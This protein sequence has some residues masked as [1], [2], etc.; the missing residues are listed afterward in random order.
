MHRRIMSRSLRTASVR[1]GFEK[2][3]LVKAGLVRTGLVVALAVGPAGAALGQAEPSPMDGLLGGPPVQVEPNAPSLVERDFEGMMRP[4][5]VR[6][7]IA[8]MGLL[9]LTDA[10]RKAVDEL[11]D[12]RAALVD[13]V[14]Y[15]NLELLTQLQ[16]A[17][18]N[19]QSGE[20]RKP[21]DAANRRA[22]AGQ[23][24]EAVAPLMAQEP[25]AEHFAEALPAEHRDQYLAIV[26]E[27]HEAQAGESAEGMNGAMNE[28]R[29]PRG[30]RSPAMAGVRLEMR[31]AV[32]RGRADR[33]ERG[34]QLVEMLDLTP[35]QEAEVRA[36]LRAF[37]DAN[38]GEQP[39]QAQRRELMQRIL[40]TLPEDQRRRA[41]E[42]MRNRRQP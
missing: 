14:V 8:A 19:A 1:Q 37:G 13:R 23:F 4:L 31:A 25:L 6:P 15:D 12:A 2:S 18:A 7:E 33:Q 21:E 5:D 41:M 36:M 32:E 17:R 24:R 42:N 10:E 11:I 9:G 40:A 20:E 27:W 29:R 26:K 34:A 38:D 39:T 22:V 3:G 28:Q 16:Q 30:L 35:E